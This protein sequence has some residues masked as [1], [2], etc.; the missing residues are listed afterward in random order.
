MF[1]NV[2]YCLTFRAG[3]E[4]NFSTL[5]FNLLLKHRLYLESP[6]VLRYSKS[7]SLLDNEQ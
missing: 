5:N 7:Y 3:S 2:S 1:P 4:I 6:W